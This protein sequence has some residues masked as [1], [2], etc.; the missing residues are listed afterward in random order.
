M[1]ETWRLTRGSGGGGRCSN[2]RRAT[3]CRA[4]A[5]VLHHLQLLRLTLLLLLLLCVVVQLRSHRVEYLVKLEMFKQVISLFH[6]VVEVAFDARDG[7]L[8]LLLLIFERGH[9]LLHI[10]RRVS[11]AASSRVAALGRIST[12]AGGGRWILPRR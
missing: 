8:D 11:F 7:L 6:F 4:I 9:F 2:A 5:L 1:S 12:G 10:S 3:P